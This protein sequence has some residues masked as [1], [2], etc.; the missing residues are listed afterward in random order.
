[1]TPTPVPG[2]VFVQ[3]QSGAI[4]TIAMSISAG[5]ILIA[6]LLMMIVILLFVLVFLVAVKAK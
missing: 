5:E 4:G 6:L 2:D 1:M 3:L